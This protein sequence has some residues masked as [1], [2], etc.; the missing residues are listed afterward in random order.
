MDKFIYLILILLPTYLLRFEIL[1]VPFTV[2]EVLILGLFVFFLYKTKLRF[3]LSSYKH[4]VILFLVAGTAGSIIAGGDRAALGLWKAYALEPV[5]FFLVFVNIKPDFKKVVKALSLGGLFVAVVGIIQYFT[6]YGIPSPWNMEGDYRVTSIF[7]Y[8]NAVGLYLTPVI[9]LALGYLIKFRK[10]AWIMF[11]VAALG[12]AAVLFSQTQGAL[13]G[14]IFGFFILG[15]LTKK[16][17]WVFLIF[18]LGGLGILLVGP[19]TR[20]ILLFQDTS[21]EVRLALW[22]GTANLLQAH[23]WAGAGLGRFPEMYSEY[24]LNRHVELLLYP[25][26]LFLDFWAEFGILGLAWIGAVLLKYFGQGFWQRNKQKTILIAAMAGVVLYGMV[27]VVYFKNDL[28]LMFW[29]LIG[30]M[31]ITFINNK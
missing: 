23:P 15:L 16:Y 1:G 20:E 30:L 21:G 25:H 13:V 17:R 22:Q 26:N 6:G 9:L 5:L 28:A 4:L 19:E 27:D 18:G 12:S 31:E 10:K 24:K 29:T 8:P 14:I 7:E 11:G 3:S 2:L